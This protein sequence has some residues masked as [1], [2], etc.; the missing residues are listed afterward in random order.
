MAAFEALSKIFTKTIGERIVTTMMTGYKYVAE[1]IKA[2]GI[3]HLF[4]VPTIMIPTMA[5]LE[6]T[7]IKRVTCHDEK[8][9][10]YMADGYARASYRPGICLAQNVGSMNL[11]AGLRDGRMAG[12][13]IIAITG[14]A[15]T[16]SRYR[17][18]YQE[19]E[20]FAVFEP[21]TKMSVEVDHVRLLPNLL[22][23]AFR[24][25]TMHLRM[26]GRHGNV[27]AEESEFELTFEDRFS[28]YPASGRK[29]ISKMST[30]LSKNCCRPRGR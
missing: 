21:V 27:L 15:D 25:A 2:Q 19:V 9:A 10:A 18:V 6:D 5:E 12:S 29:L 23:Q 8:A 7:D 16:A 17:H 13:P 4:F 28:R 14:G 3:T 11:A 26:R 30:P 24:S 1:A 22:R 20:D